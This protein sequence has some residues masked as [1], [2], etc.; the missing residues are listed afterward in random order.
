MVENE[1]IFTNDNCIGCNKCISVCNCL[2]ANVAELISNNKNKIIVNSDKCIACGACINVCEHNA[3]EY[4]DDT[5]VFFEDLKKGERIS[6]LIAPSFKANYPN[7][8]ENILGVLKELGVNK[9][10]DVSFGADITTWAYINYIN[11]YDF[12]GGISQPC[13]AIVSYIEK[14]VPDLIPKLF[15]VQSPMM[16]GAIYAKKYMGLSDKL[17]FIGPCIAKK[18]EINDLNNKGYI[19]YNVTFDHLIK[20]IK[21][22]KLKGKPYSYELDCGLG[23]IYPMPGGLKENVYWFCGESTLVRQIEGEQ[24]IYKF[25]Q[26]NKDRIKG[27]KTPYLF[28]DALNCSL[29]CLYGTGIEKAK[30]ENDDNLYSIM[31]IKDQSK[32][33]IFFS[34]WSKKLSPKKRLRMLNKQFYKLN[35]NDFTRKY[36]NKM[37]NDVVYKPSESQFEEI[38]SSMNKYED[39]QRH[40]DCSCCGYSSCTDMAVA[41]YNKLNHKENCIYY[42]KNEIEKENDLANKL[43]IEVEE[44]KEIIKNQKK[45]VIDIVS[46]I[47]IEFEELYTSI[48]SMLKVNNSNA[49]ESSSISVEVEN[50]SNF[51]VTLDKSLKNILCLLNELG[52]NNKQ[53]VDIATRTNLLSLNATIEAARAG[54]LGKGFT[55]VAN[56]INKLADSS[57][58]TAVH[59]NTNHNKINNSIELILKEAEQLILVISKVSNRINNLAAS[60]EEIAASVDI[61]SNVTDGIKDKLNMLSQSD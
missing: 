25:L 24:E 17:A 40:I 34:A 55:V 6:I 20:H 23:S 32:K 8:Y 58:N 61:I 52:D 36:S 31:K 13:P 45:N 14:Y 4:I 7:E 21:A 43:N 11:K 26:K 19:S 22:N 29:G 49:E 44:E 41:I 59:S 57:K 10:I 33:N 9:I 46:D 2:A 18:S 42:I 16:C 48:D 50:I 54:E 51:C 37:E 35:L 53:V 28:I 15:P 39:Y 1:L 12:K 38:F 27:A 60:T 56:E 47:S 5:K 3:R 30:K